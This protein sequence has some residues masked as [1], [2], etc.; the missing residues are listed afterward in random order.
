MAREKHSRKEFLGISGIAAAGAVGAGGVVGTRAASAAAA[1]AGALEPDL[2]VLNARVHTMDPQHPRVE[3]FAIKDGRFAAVGSTERI[4]G[5]AGR[6]TER[7]DAQGMTIVPGFID[8][9]V[10]AAGTTLV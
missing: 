8:T 10:H 5:M 4:E 1:A 2:V 3:A 7:F 6:R 9:H